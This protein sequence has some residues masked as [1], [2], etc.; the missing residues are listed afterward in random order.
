MHETRIIMGMPVSLAVSDKSVRKLD[1][2]AVFAEFVAID[3]QFSPFKDDSEVSR[4][5]RREITE[6]DFTPRM[7][8]IVALC[9]KA[10][11]D[12]A[13][14]FNISRPDG[15]IDPCGM[16]KGW[17]IRN[18]ARQL[19]DMGFRNYCVEAGGDIQCRGINDKGGEWTVGI[20]NPFSRDEIVKVIRPRGHGVAT[21]G[22]YIRGDHIYNPHTGRYGSDDI[23]S[24][25]VIGPDVLEADRY[26]TAAFAMG[27]QGI[28]FIEHLPDLEGYEIDAAGTARMTSG[29]KNY[30][31]C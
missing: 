13:G 22:N 12:T 19:D 28:H 14:Y 21:S 18:A 7:R 27:R 5:N 15:T 11:Q 25:T 20:R 8:E 4:F 16:V 6:W 31:S 24:L 3:A 23:V 30:L 10:R 26:A 29:L 2:E 9:E 17:A 1:L